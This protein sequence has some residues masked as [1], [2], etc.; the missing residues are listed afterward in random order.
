MDFDFVDDVRGG[1]FHRFGRLRPDRKRVFVVSWE[2]CIH[3]RGGTV[4]GDHGILYNLCMESGADD[5]T[6][7]KYA[8]DFVQGQ[9]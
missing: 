9:K 2:R 8:N 1:F 4:D 3:K 5:G 6:L 7:T